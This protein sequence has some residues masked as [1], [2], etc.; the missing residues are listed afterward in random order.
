MH[1]YRARVR[2]KA[3]N[4]NWNSHVQSAF[5]AFT[6]YHSSHPNCAAIA[7]HTY[8]G[9]STSTQ[10]CVCIIRMHIP[11]NIRTY[12]G[13]VLRQTFA[14]QAKSNGA[15]CW[16]SNKSFQPREW[17]GNAQFHLYIVHIC[18]HNLPFQPTLKGALL[19]IDASISMLP[20]A[21]EGGN[22]TCKSNGRLPHLQHLG[23]P[24]CIRFQPSTLPIRHNSHS[25]P[26]NTTALG[27]PR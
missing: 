14:L 19:H 13:N 8:I 25:H 11:T 6:M 21:E 16:N 7:T 17:C 10:T 4:C 23:F 12:N 9:L 22:W 3:A 2:R 15:R 1:L 5:A 18:I 26:Q 27:V 24:K 20:I